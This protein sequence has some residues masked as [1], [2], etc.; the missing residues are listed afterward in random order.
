MTAGTS[1]QSWRTWSD[2]PR[3]RR[4]GRGRHY[5]AEHNGRDA[6]PAG[7][8]HGDKHRHG[9]FRP[10]GAGLQLAAR[11][12]GLVG[13]RGQDAHIDAPRRHQHYGER[14]RRQSRPA[15]A[16]S[17]CPASAVHPNHRG[18]RWVVRRVSQVS[19][20]SL[21]QSGRPWGTLAT[22]RPNRDTALHRD[23]LTGPTTTNMVPRNEVH[24]CRGHSCL[25]RQRAMR[26]PDVEWDFVGPLPSA[27]TR[28][29]RRDDRTLLNGT[30]GSFA[31]KSPS[32]MFPSGMAGGPPSTGVSAAGLGRQPSPGSIKRRRS[33]RC[34]RQPRPRP[35]GLL[36][37]IHSL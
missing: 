3:P 24:T 27:A 23:G 11:H 32:E 13:V 7:A 35:I 4:P 16:R 2:Y 28:R 8:V 26:L 21:W 17:A 15:S 12:K 14:C 36:T 22:S 20:N 34:R 19:R 31:P 18:P 1:T 37:K 30:H 25:F 29:P 10:V 5:R 6:F 33:G 9:A